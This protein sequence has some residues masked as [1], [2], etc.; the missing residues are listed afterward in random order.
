MASVDAVEPPDSCDMRMELAYDPYLVRKLA[1]RER[2]PVAASCRKRPSLYFQPPPSTF[3]VRPAFLFPSFFTSTPQNTRKHLERLHQPPSL[4]TLSPVEFRAFPN[5]LSQQSR[6]S[7]AT[8][9]SSTE[10]V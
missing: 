3:F 2:V 8:V 7:Q 9:R 5:W 1:A 10:V 4:S 6:Q